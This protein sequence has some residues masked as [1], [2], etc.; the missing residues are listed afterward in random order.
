MIKFDRENE[1][2]DEYFYW[3]VGLVC[4]NR[5]SSYISFEKLLRYLH[6]TEFTYS[7]KRDKNRAGDG[8]GLRWRFVSDYWRP[9]SYDHI[10]ACLDGPC[11][12]FEMMVAL[13][14]RCEESIMDNPS[15]GDRT[16][17]WFWGMVV[18]LGLGSMTDERFDAGY[19]EDT[20]A[21]FLSRKYD[22]NGK[23]GLFTI[24]N[25]DQDLRKVEIFHQLCW[26]LDSIM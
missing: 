8:I 7:I 20:V 26:Y 15:M 11:S 5:Y 22:P 23:G 9:V 2:R 10:L 24:R 19:V 21:R 14:I 6:D 16:G 3:L 4:K 18:N 17:Q 1:I 25:C 12:V 13:A